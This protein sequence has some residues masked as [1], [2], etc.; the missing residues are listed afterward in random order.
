MAMV[1][2]MTPLDAAFLEAEDEDRHT[3]MAIAS[4][5]VMQGPAP[6]H[7]EFVAAIR[8]R[9]AL[10]P[11]YRQ[12]P[13]AIPL[14]LAAPVWV[15]DPGFDLSYHIRRTAVPAPGGDEALSRLIARVMSQR[16]DRDR[17]LWEY[18]VVEN[19]A[20]GQWAVISKV[21]HCMVD[22][23]SGTHL[24]YALFDASPERGPDVPDA[25]VPT[26]APS[27]LRLTAD[28]LRELARTPVDQLSMLARELR[29][30]RAFARRVAD[31]GRGL[32]TLARALL[33]ASA[34]SLTGPIGQPRRY[35]MARASLPAALAVARKHRVTLN[36]VVLAAISAGFRTLLLERGESP[37]THAVRSLVPV[38]VRAPG[39][40]GI[41]DNRVSLMLAFLP[42]H[43][44]D[45]L[46]RLTAVHDHLCELKAS[47]EA[48][49]GE[50][51]T[52]LARHEPFPPISLGV[53]M[54]AHLPQR[55]II[56]VTTNVP[57]PRKPLYI[58]GRRLLTVYPYVPIAAR[59]RTGVSIF[60]YCDQVT[61][62]V[63][64]DLDSGLDADLLARAIEA[65]LAELVAASGVPVAEPAAPVA[66]PAA[67]ATEPSAPVAGPVVSVAE[68][69][70][71]PTGARAPKRTRKS[72]A[73]DTRKPAA[74]KAASK[75]AAPKAATPEPVTPRAAGAKAAA[76][77]PAGPKVA[78]PRP[79]RKRAAVPSTAVAPAE[80]PPV[81][82][83]KRAAAAS[84]KPARTAAASVTLPPKATATSAAEP[85]RATRATRA[86]KDTRVTRAT[87]TSKATGPETTPATG[88]A[89]PA[90]PARGR[91]GH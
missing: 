41:T 64:S 31:T 80:V 88:G 51:M 59:L 75:A 33:P 13:R 81:V 61:F 23:V 22:G 9:L 83:A 87:R 4:V 52:S 2:R 57:G 36:D 7:E 40:E 45:P 8:G 79:G 38:S 90:R 26:P 70:A 21:H 16:L 82:T 14:D 19:L 69:V 84:A 71:K 73:G 42:V 24:Y 60:T 68:P 48:E 50:A 35:A 3:S 47:R 53:R 56:T 62:G 17:P 54:A 20:G 76:P 86:T 27:T 91:S 37:D 34:S 43:V 78:A 63:T 10:V 30:P 46:E 66:Q 67:P 6:S 11:R 28:A 12:K 39:D 74:P 1:D 58:L 5:A 15:D 55:M 49:A 32:A 44:A 29:E 77:K 85:A 18:W 25:W 65:G 89:E 72:T